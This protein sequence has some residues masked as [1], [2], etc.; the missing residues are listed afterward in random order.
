MLNTVKKKENYMVFAYMRVSTTDKQDFD[1]QIYILNNCGYEISERNIYYDKL[2]GK[3]AKDRE[4]YQILKKITRKDDIIIFPELSR[5]SRNY[6]QIAQ[7]MAYFKNEGIKLIFLDMPFLSNCGDDLAQK[8]I[9]D[10]CIKLFSYVAEQERINTAKRIKQK[11]TSMKEAGVELGR[12]KL[13][14]NEEQLKIMEQYI[15]KYPEYIT[16][17]EASEKMGINI[18]SFY[19]QLRLYKQKKI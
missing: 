15:N 14:L 10:I 16:A 5:F 6:D 4:Q 7:E 17:K 18:N 9:S 11:L 19:K 8:L 2:S 3:E 12:P 13:V 1:R